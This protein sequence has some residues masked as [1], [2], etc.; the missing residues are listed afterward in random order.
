MRQDATLPGRPVLSSTTTARQAYGYLLGNLRTGGRADV[1]IAFWTYWQAGPVRYRRASDGDLVPDTVR[2]PVSVWGTGNNLFYAP[3]DNAGTQYRTLRQHAITAQHTI[4]PVPQLAGTFDESKIAAFDPLSRV[5]LGPYQ[6]TSATPASAASRQALGGG[7]L[8]PSM[9]LGGY[10][11]QPVQMITTLAALP[12]VE[13]RKY[14]GDAQ[15][16]R[17]PI[18]VI[19]VRVAGVTGPDPVSLNRIKEVAEQIEL[20]THLTVDI[21]AGSSPAPTTVALPAGRFGYPALLLSEDWVKKGVAISILNAVDRSSVALFV[22]ILVVC[23]LFV[24]N[25]ATAAVRARRPELGVLSA[26]GWTRPRLFT[27]VLGEVAL[28]GLIAGALAALLSPP[29]AAALGLHA[30]PARAALAI[31]V[32]VAVAVVAGAVPAWLAAR[33]DPV[34]SVRPPVLAVRR[35]RQPSRITGLAVVNVLRTPGRTLVGAL[36][37]AIG[38]MS[39]TL[40]VAVTLAFRGA[41]VGT[42]LGNVVTVQVRGV[43]YVAVAATVALG[44]LAVADAVVDQHHRAGARNWPRSARSAGPSRCCTAW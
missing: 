11:S 12:T 30:S 14:T 19:R 33:A 3:L 36:S 21:V 23:A 15:L 7:D 39:L 31:P 32:A 8:L 18:S 17:A 4:S 25:S 20:R 16:R 24:A 9:N 34:A 5:P 6:P 22:L 41:V 42:L 13:S 35:A 27:A 10:V 40:L 44:V 28:I 43:D 1:G 2:N 38:V 29:L 37:L 26:L